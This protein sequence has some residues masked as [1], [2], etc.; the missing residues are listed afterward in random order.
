[1]LN[2]GRARQVSRHDKYGHESCCVSHVRGENPMLVVSC[3]VSECKTR[4]T[5][6]VWANKQTQIRS[7]PVPGLSVE[8]L[9]AYGVG[10]AVTCSERTQLGRAEMEAKPVTRLG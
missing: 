9:G 4:N 10:N 3:R 5:G 6:A 2:S 8:T 1:M 7:D